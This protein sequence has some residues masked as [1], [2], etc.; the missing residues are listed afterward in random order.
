MI[1]E[2]FINTDR[3]R[4]NLTTLTYKTGIIPKAMTLKKH[5]TYD[6]FLYDFCTIWG[7]IYDKIAA[8][9]YKF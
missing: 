6:Y 1:Q 7:N 2:R 5:L 4:H 9:N 8:L 3:E